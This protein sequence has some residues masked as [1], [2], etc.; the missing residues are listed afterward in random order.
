MSNYVIICHHVILTFGFAHNDV[1]DDIAMSSRH[2]RH[3]VM[4]SMFDM[5]MTRRN[6]LK[7]DVLLSPVMTHSA[8]IPYEDYIILEFQKNSTVFTS[9]ETYNAK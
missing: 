1:H 8:K 5:L 4:S 2:L 9:E 6:M 7:L 3:D